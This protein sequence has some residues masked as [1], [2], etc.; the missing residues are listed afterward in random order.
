[1]LSLFDLYQVFSDNLLFSFTVFLSQ[2][3]PNGQAH[4]LLFFA[5]SQGG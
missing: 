3:K 2:I 1:M 4:G 5:T